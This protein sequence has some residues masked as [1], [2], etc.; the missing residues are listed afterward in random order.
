MS[1][2]EDA[3]KPFLTLIIKG[4]A[5]TL[6]AAQ[7]ELV[8]K[9]ATLK[10]IVCEHDNRGTEVT[11]QADR[12]AFM[13]DG[14]IPAYFNIYLLSHN[15]ASRVGYVRT[16]QTA[17]M[18]NGAPLPPLEGRTKNTEQISVILG[19]AMLHINA[20]RVDGFMIE[21]NLNMPAVVGRR[22]WPPNVTPLTWPAD[23]VISCDQMRDLAYA[24]EKIMALPRANWGGDLPA[25][26]A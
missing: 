24:M 8:A 13:T 23:P 25:T 3:A 15:C 14:I 12:T 11:P 5:V 20:A 19:S 6:D 7:L 21:N 18:T 22:I 26:S 16:S 2:I 1:G 10:A 9:W 4:E 17:S